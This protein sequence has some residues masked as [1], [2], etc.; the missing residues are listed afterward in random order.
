[1]TNH[2]HLLMETSDANLAKGMRQ[3]NGVYTQRFN[4]VHGRCGHVFQGR[5]K[6]ILVQKETYLT[7]LARYIVLNPVRAGMVSRAE[8][9]PWSSYRATKGEAA[10]PEWLRRD[11]SLSAFGA[12]EQAAVASYRRV[13]KRTGSREKDGV[14]SKP[15]DKGVANA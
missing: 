6:A 7:E 4:G 15:S 14:W 1:M 10:C 11:W 3:L 13:A 9:W 5:Y 2:Y 8:D 12:T